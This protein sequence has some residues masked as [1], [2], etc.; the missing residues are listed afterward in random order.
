[1]LVW[2]INEQV[3][4]YEWVSLRRNYG[5]VWDTNK[6][7]KGALQMRMAFTSGYDGKWVWAEYVLPVDWKIG[8]IY[9][10]GVQIYDIAKEG[11]LASQCGDKPWK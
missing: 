4:S 6:V 10:T 8:A 1:M 3:G 7:P 9:D 5:A 2:S 11:C